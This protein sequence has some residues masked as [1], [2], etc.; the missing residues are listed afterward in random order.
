MGK[1]AASTDKLS[2]AAAAVVRD[3]WVG[4][5]SVEVAGLDLPGVKAALA[6]LMAHDA[7]LVVAVSEGYDG[8]TLACIERR[9]IDAAGVPGAWVHVR[10]A[11]RAEVKDLAAWARDLAALDAE[12]CCSTFSPEGGEYFVSRNGSAAF[13]AAIFSGAAVAHYDFDCWSC[14]CPVTGRRFE[15]RDWAYSQHDEA[16]VNPSRTRLACFVTDSPSVARA[17]EAAGFSVVRS[18]AAGIGHTGR[19]AEVDSEEDCTAVRPLRVRGMSHRELR[20]A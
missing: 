1:Q 4:G 12:V 19:A 14:V 3:L 6:G 15:T 7:A 11:H 2:P 17:L 16:W 20:A 5:R 18:S 10:H 9:N 13:V 8:S